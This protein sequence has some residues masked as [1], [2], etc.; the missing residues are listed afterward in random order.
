MTCSHSVTITV[1]L[2][3]I[4]QPQPTGLRVYVGLSARTLDNQLVLFAAFG[5]TQTDVW[6]FVAMLPSQL[7]STQVYL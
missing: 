7:N 1:N 6:F 5:D 2:C 4:S 3:L